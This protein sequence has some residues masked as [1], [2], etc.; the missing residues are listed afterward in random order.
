MDKYLSVMLQLF[1]RNPRYD[2]GKMD[3]RITSHRSFILLMYSIKEKEGRSRVH[4]SPFI[5][6]CLKLSAIYLLNLDF[7]MKK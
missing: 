5:T 1:F 6:L 4:L 7:S 2:L 3:C